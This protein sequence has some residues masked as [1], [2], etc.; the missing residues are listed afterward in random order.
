MKWIRNVAALS[1]LVFLTPAFAEIGVSDKEIL[2]GQSAPLSGN[3]AELG[4]QYNAG[5]RTYLDWVN[6][7]GGVFGRKIKLVVRDDAYDPAKAE[8]NVNYLIDEAHVFALLGLVGTPTGKVEVPIATKNRVPVVGILSGARVFRTPVNPYVFNVRASYCAEVLKSLEHMGPGGAA[9]LGIVA[10]DDGYGEDVSHCVEDYIEKV[11]GA[12][13]HKVKVKRGSLEVE[14]AMRELASFNPSAIILASS[15]QPVGKMITLLRNETTTP[16]YYNV[17]FVGMESLARE[18]TERVG[19][20]V[21]VT[22]VVPP[23]KFDMSPEGKY[24]RD[25]IGEDASYTSYE[26]FL[27]AKLFVAALKR[28]GREPSRER[29]VAAL[30]AA[31]IDL[32]NMIVSYRPDN[33]SGSNY[34]EETMITYKGNIGL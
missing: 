11:H 24:Y 3:N 14:S 26:G 15:Y 23:S 4:E 19:R 16:R 12:I 22:Q 21:I 20:G 28:A 32:G 8:V 34:V 2:V 30:E 13:V 5:I 1:A 9:R 18:M 31:P 25:N 6:E 33:H 17:S 7:H 29:L 10:Q 27:T